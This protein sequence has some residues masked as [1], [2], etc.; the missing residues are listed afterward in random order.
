M[1]LHAY[2]KLVGASKQQVITPEEIKLLFQQYKQLAAKTGKQV[3]WAYGDAAF[4][5]AIK[6]TQEGKGKWFYL[7]SA[8]DQYQLIMLGVDKEIVLDDNGTE[9]IQNYIQITLP[10]TSTFGDKGKANEFC[11]F[12]AEQLQGELHL[13]NG[14]IMYYYPRK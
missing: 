8:H 12:I 6:E 7:E 9:R 4:P 14:R 5:Y 13:F 2:I 3:G 1:A 10:E 11:K